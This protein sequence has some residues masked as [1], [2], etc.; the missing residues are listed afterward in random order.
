MFLSTCFI[1]LFYQLFDQHVINILSTFYQP[2]INFHQHFINFVYQPFFM[3]LSSTVYQFY[4]LFIN[5][6]STFYQLFINFWSTLSTFYQLS[7]NFVSAVR[8]HFINT[9]LMSCCFI[10]KYPKLSSSLTLCYFAW[11]SQVTIWYFCDQGV[12]VVNAMCAPALN[13]LW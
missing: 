2:F 13:L 10:W 12:V 11:T 3:N 6:S 7:I 4:Q 9:W 5:F 1:N 8:Q